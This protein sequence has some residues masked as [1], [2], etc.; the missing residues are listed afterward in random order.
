MI[1]KFVGIKVSGIRWVAVELNEAIKELSQC[2]LVRI[3]IWPV[4][5]HYDALVQF[6]CPIEDG[7]G[8]EANTPSSP[9]V[10]AR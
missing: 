5:S 3:D 7:H 6:S 8:E 1:P 4:E 10:P 9:I 2:Q